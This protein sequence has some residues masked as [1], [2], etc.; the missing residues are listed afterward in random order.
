LLLT[1]RWLL[2]F[3]N[4]WSFKSPSCLDEYYKMFF[5]A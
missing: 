2:D 3:T 4:C 1:R 5:S